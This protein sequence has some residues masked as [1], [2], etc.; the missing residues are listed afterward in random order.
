MSLPNSSGVRPAASAAPPPPVLPPGPR[1][2]FHGLFV[3]PK[4]GLSA[5]QSL[6]YG[7]TFVLPM[8]D[9]PA[10]LRRATIGASSSA[11]A[12]AR[13]GTPPVVG[14]PWTS[15]VSLIVNGSPSSG[16]SSPFAR[17]ASAARAA[18]RA[19]SKSGVTIALSAGLKRSIRRR[20]RSSSS[21]ADT[22]R[23]R[24]AASIA[25]AV[26]NPSIIAPPTSHQVRDRSPAVAGT[27]RS[28][29]PPARR[30]GSA[31]GPPGTPRAPESRSAGRPWTCRSGTPCPGCRSGSRGPST[32]TATGS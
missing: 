25:V 6:A 11:M 22:S 28:P 12:S 7:G 10:A 21:T 16:R 26:V 31:C 5:W 9:A 24:R 17:A 27:R 19:R 14:S 13:S 2:R 20:W 23:A 4:S 30:T 3:R 29:P 18:S 1:S 15:M 8:M 32:P